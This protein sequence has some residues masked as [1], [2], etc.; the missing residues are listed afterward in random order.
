VAAAEAPARPVPMTRMW[1]FRLLF[2]FTSFEL[3]R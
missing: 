1:N 2:A 3:K